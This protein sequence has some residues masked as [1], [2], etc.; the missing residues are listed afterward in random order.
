MKR[1]TLIILMLILLIS[2]V[3]CNNNEEI[4]NTVETI[5]PKG[6]IKDDEEELPPLDKS[7]TASDVLE[8][9]Y[10]ILTESEYYCFNITAKRKT[11][12][13]IGDAEPDTSTNTYNITIHR[14]SDGVAHIVDSTILG[15]NKSTRVTFFTP[16]MTADTEFT[17]LYMQ[18]SDTR[19]DS[20]VPIKREEAETTLQTADFF[21]MIVNS[22]HEYDWGDDMAL[23]LKDE[24]YTLVFPLNKV[25]E[26]IKSQD[27]NI[28]NSVFL[29]ICEGF[30][31][32]DELPL[33][34]VTFDT[35]FRIKSATINRLYS[36]N[37]SETSLGSLSESTEVTF[38]LENV[39]YDKKDD[40]FFPSLKKSVESFNKTNGILLYVPKDIQTFKTLSSIQQVLYNGYVNIEKSNSYHVDLD[41]KIRTDSTN[42]T[43]NYTAS[44]EKQTVPQ[45]F[46]GTFSFK[47]NLIENGIIHESYT[48][49][50]P[51]YFERAFRTL[52]FKL[53][54]GQQEFFVSVDP[55]LDP[56]RVD[57]PIT[58]PA[59]QFFYNDIGNSAT[60][61]VKDDGTIVVEMDFN[62]FYNLVNSTSNNA[63]KDIIQHYD[64]TRLT[65][66]NGIVSIEFNK[67]GY[68]TKISMPETRFGTTRN[69]EKYYLTFTCTFSGYNEIPY[70]FR[71]DLVA[72]LDKYNNNS[73]S[74]QYQ[75]PSDDDDLNDVVDSEDTEIPTSIDQ[76]P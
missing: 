30:D 57:Y 22:I 40:T 72:A 66:N 13:K 60:L 31:M 16:Y 68:L 25:Y 55:I 53:Q 34:K 45:T 39:S 11:I 35:L 67:D 70:T 10:K 18:L 48:V 33:L 69:A 51:L 7:L 59:L 37:K 62:K 61:S 75:L 73:K 76:K 5:D 17:P 6:W 24:Q 29:S 64:I 44:A 2:M 50:Y 15:T 9:G 8:K 28:F 20:G 54:K 41:V 65:R 71:D 52:S 49:A 12:K 1:I 19:I 32:E 56:R 21:G 47:T 42:E 58:D 26:I 36:S 3:G 63:F 27:P 4:D 46:I 43:K 14:S 74:G 38:S 23:V